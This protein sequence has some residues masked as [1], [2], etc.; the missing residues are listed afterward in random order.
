MLLHR[1]PLSWR[2]APPKAFRPERSVL[3]YWPPRSSPLQCLCALAH[4]G[5]PL[6]YHLYSDRDPYSLAPGAGAYLRWLDRGR[7]LG[8]TRLHKTPC[9]CSHGR[10]RGFLPCPLAEEVAR[11]RMA[12]LFTPAYVPCRTC[13]GCLL[14]Q[15]RHPRGSN[16]RTTV[17]R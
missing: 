7:G 3:V 17:R 1:A 15:R 2:L 4:A 6:R 16:L 12:A 8:N 9:P 10:F 11:A 5:D 14:H 13:P